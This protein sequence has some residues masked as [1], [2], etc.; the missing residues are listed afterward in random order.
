M[1][2]VSYVDPVSGEPYFHNDETGVTQWEVPD[3]FAIDEEGGLVDLADPGTQAGDSGP[4]CWMDVAVGGKS[5]RRIV[6][7]LFASLAPKTADNFRALCTGEAGTGARRH[8]AAAF[9]P[10][11]APTRGPGPSPRIQAGPPL[12]GDPIPPHRAGLHVPGRRHHSRSV[13]SP[14]PGS[15]PATRPRALATNPGDGSGGESIYG[16]TF[17]DEWLEGKHSRPFL[18]SMANSGPNT[19]RS[20]R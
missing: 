18:L 17:E 14:Q 3:G 19:V 7:R 6:F 5:P 16:G 20:P 12:Q 9:A 1:G 4:R 8:H 15:A 13:P 11:W 2:W 10:G